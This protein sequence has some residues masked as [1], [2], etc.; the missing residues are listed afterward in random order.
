MKRTILIALGGLALTA[1]AFAQA[2]ADVMERALLGAP[3]QVRDASTVIQ[4][5]ADNTYDTLK[6]GWLSLFIYKRL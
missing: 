5:K 6:K 1:G 3:R 2:P 4:W